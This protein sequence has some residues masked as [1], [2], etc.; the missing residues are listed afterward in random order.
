MLEENL[1]SGF[2]T[3]TVYFPETIKSPIHLNPQRPS[4]NNHP[5]TVNK[6]C[7]LSGIH[8]ILPSLTALELSP[9]G[10]SV[11]LKSGFWVYKIQYK[12]WILD[13]WKS[14]FCAFA[15]LF[16][17]TVLLYSP[18]ST[19][20]K[21]FYRHPHIS[22]FFFCTWRIHL[23]LRNCKWALMQQ[24]SN[25]VFSTIFFYVFCLKIIIQ[26]MF[27]FFRSHTLAR[28]LNVQHHM[29][30]NYKDIRD[31]TR[32]GKHKVLEKNKD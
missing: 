1:F 5:V 28:I 25:H 32:G 6:T 2:K 15:P 31:F 17:V 22:Y 27:L 14:F 21:L 8:F 16:W 30:C 23:W 3:N 26:V 19:D 29:I 18:T 12:S 4:R 9:H 10:I 13:F 24:G 7:T 20:L 11:G